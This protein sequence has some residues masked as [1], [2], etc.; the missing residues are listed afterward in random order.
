VS[1]RERL[2]IAYQYYDVVIGDQPHVIQTL[3]V[4]KESFPREFRPVN[5]LAFVYN[6]LGQFERAVEEGLEAIRRN[7]S[8]G[9]PYSNLALAYRG[10]GRFEEAR[11]TAE[12]AVSLKVDTMPTRVL[13]YLLEESAG[14][15]EAAA[16]LLEKAKADPQEF[17]IIGARAQVSASRGRVR[18]ARQLYEEAVRLAEQRNLAEAATAYLARASGMDLAYGNIDRARSEARRALARKPGYETQMAAALTLAES[19]SVAEAQAIAGALSSAH[20]DHTIINLI[21]GPIVRAAIELSRKR[22]EQGIEQLRIAAPYET[23]VAAALAPIYL[24]GQLYLMEGSGLK[25]ADEFQ[26]ILDHRGTDPFSPFCALAP[27]G[28]ARARA[29]AG[30]TAGSIQA[31]EEFLSAWAAADTDVPILREARDEYSRI[32]LGKH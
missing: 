25:A 7:P 4:W 24:R 18:E 26:R 22:P 16:R 2:N 19:G 1:E 8:H 27:L 21:L 31:Y 30:N 32:K 14:D 20:P 12:Q 29:I 3:E 13:L 10:L 17:D 9:F 6:F 15:R 23:G 28:L 11:K 5:S